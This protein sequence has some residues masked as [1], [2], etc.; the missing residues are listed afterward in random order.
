MQEQNITYSRIFS[1]VCACLACLIACWFSYHIYGAQPVI[2]DE[3]CILNQAQELAQF[4][5]LGDLRKIP[6]PIYD[7]CTVMVKNT[8]YSVYA[9]GQ[10]LVFAF[11]II[12]GIPLWIINPIIF[13]LSVYAL[14]RLAQL[15]Y[16]DDLL[17]VVTA[18]LAAG[19][20]WFIMMSSSHWVHPLSLLLT[21]LLLYGVVQYKENFQLRALILV[22]V[23][24]G[25]L[26]ITR[27]LTAL[28][29]AVPCI[30]LIK[31]I[32]SRARKEQ[33][34]ALLV[35]LVIPLMFLGIFAAFNY[36]ANGNPFLTGYE[37]KYGS[38]HNPGFG[39]AP[40]G[41][42]HSLTIGLGNIK[43]YALYVHE[44]LLAWP[45][46]CFWLA[47]LGMILGSS[48]TKIRPL[49]CSSCCIFF[50]YVFYWDY[51]MMIGARFV[52]EAT[53][54]FLVSTAAA[55]VFLARKIC[56]GSQKYATVLCTSIALS[57]SLYAYFVRWPIL[58]KA[59]RQQLSL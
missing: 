38:A 41:L 51:S 27:P 13:G 52:Y 44:T 29:A 24:L 19:S 30:F 42:T 28:A 7:F 55:I 25:M 47:G 45:L 50:A 18:A 56:R 21:I 43:N 58:L 14:S 49:V 20:P 15:L 23:A 39:Q 32:Y 3:V 31:P 16:K 26:A 59:L 1:A 17:A 33:Y 5:V 2:G 8:W 35:L 53:P 57:L 37:H 4:R 10:A 40:Y 6:E 9:P 11:F 34:Q 22:A 48:Y 12:L 36:A 54:L 46:G